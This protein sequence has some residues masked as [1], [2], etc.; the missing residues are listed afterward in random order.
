M[1]MNEEWTPICKE[2]T[3]V[4]FLEDSRRFVEETSGIQ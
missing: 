4:K 2:T 3:S 1:V